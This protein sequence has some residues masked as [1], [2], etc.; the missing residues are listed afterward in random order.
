MK[1]PTTETAGGKAI[2]MVYENDL[3]EEIEDYR[4]RNRFPTRVDA[5][6]ALLRT[7]LASEKKGK[8]S[9]G[10]SGVNG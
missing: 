8:G 3:L 1:A 5:I 10:R 9:N 4:Y 7:A 6:K 2:H